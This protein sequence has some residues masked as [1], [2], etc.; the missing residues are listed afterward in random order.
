QNVIQGQTVTF[1]VR[2]SDSDSSASM[3]YLYTACA[4]ALQS[5]TLDSFSGAF[6]WDTINVSPGVYT[7]NIQA[8]GSTGGGAVQDVKITV[9]SP[10][11]SPTPPPFSTS[12]YIVGADPSKAA[13]DF[14]RKQMAV[15]PN[16][17][18]AVALLFFGPKSVNGEYGVAALGG[19]PISDITKPID[20]TRIVETF[21]SDYYNALGTGVGT[22]EHA[23]IIIAT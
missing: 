14:A 10:P 12:Y 17:D 3:Q 11:Q 2:T 15:G 7:L 22:T 9:S 19:M 20:V 4:P 13:H 5:A 6:T 21:I 16:Q 18:N 8:R 23:H 1:T